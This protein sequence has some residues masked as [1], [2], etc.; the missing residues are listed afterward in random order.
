[1]A[2]ANH[3]AGQR[4]P[5][6]LQH[7]HN[8]VDWYPWGEEAF[9]LARDL[10]R[11]LFLSIGYSTC[12]WCHVM[13]RESFV[14]EAVAAVLNAS[15]VSIKVDR[16]ERPDIDKE[17]MAACH[18]MTGSG[19]W[20]LNIVMTPSGKPFFAATYIPRNAGRGRMGLVDLLEKIALMWKERRPVIEESAE[21]VY[22]S[23]RAEE[24]TAGA[25]PV[26]RDA[27]DRAFRALERSY[28]PV[29]GGFGGA[30]KFPSPHAL[31]FLLRYWHV[32]GGTS[33]RDMALHT[34]RSMRAGGICDQ[35]GYG[36]H[37]YSTDERWLVPHFEKMLYDQA[38]MAMACAEGCLASGDA[39][40]ASTLREILEYVLR[41]LTAPEG[42]F[43][44]AEDADSEGAEGAYYLWDMKEI[45]EVLGP[46]DSDFA[47]GYFR[48]G[49][50]GNFSDP[51]GG[52][53]VGMNILH[54]AGPPDY[55]DR[56]E[57]V[58]KRLLAARAARQR[59]LRDDK[60]LADWNGLMIGAMAMGARVLDDG[61]YLAAAARAADFVSGAMMT[62]GE[63]LLHRYREGEAAITGNLD[64]YAFFAWGL[65][66]LYQAGFD[67]RHLELAGRITLS[68]M[69]YFQS[70][71]G[72][73]FFSPIDGERRIAAV[74]E[75]HDGAYPSGNAVA[76]YNLARLARLTGDPI[77]DE[78]AR[79]LLADA[80]GNIMK[81]PHAH[82]M[83]LVGLMLMQGP[84]S[85]VVVA[86]E[87]DDPA[88][89]AMLRELNR[90]Y[91]PHCM[92][93]VK[94]PGASIEGPAPFT[95]PMGSR[96]GR[97]TAYVCSEDRCFQPVHTA[98]DMLGLLKIKSS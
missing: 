47:V 69:R 8:P 2:A 6:L 88:L 49:D 17:Y 70:E 57:S 28:D 26:S 44:S 15:F 77:W 63:R 13:E 78:S 9:D 67:A 52:M 20:P 85:E 64:D 96:D 30:P 71:S 82:T 14:D 72:G 59:P 38:M 5:Y 89:L 22:A 23:L 12:H 16:E 18:M 39:L 31:I 35:L 80:G 33:A 51:A 65:I 45:W 53:D 76:L 97:A 34:L 11:P 10:D 55:S 90:T 94:H 4:S 83:F 46:E 7:L 40:L 74:R 87:R 1:M 60:I 25:G 91:L 27:L 36:F 56:A 61:R 98:A 62:A 3:L 79:R 92:V 32:T 43:Y 42:A 19:G 50:A 75:Y 68:M 93:L 95:A 84:S 48:L 81:Y 24:D 58:R 54:L 37:R 41:D 73:L 86:G 21:T 66:E 29:H